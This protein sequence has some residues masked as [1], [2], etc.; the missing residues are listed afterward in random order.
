MTFKSTQN[1]LLEVDGRLAGRFSGFSGGSMQGEVAEFKAGPNLSKH[2]VNMKVQDMVMTCGTGM[3]RGFYDWIGSSFGTSVLRKDGA[4]VQL[5][6]SQVPAG[7][8]EFKLAL[9]TG[10]VMPALDRLGNSSAFMMVT[11]SPELTRS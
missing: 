9:V 2:I 10:L 11:I 3:S 8:L 1:L 6:Q 7:R 5:S 4:V